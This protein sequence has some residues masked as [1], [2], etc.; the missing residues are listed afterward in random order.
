[1]GP[2]PYLALCFF[3]AGFCSNSSRSISSASFFTVAGVILTVTWEQVF[4]VPGI[5]RPPPAAG[6]KTEAVALL[7]QI[8][9]QVPDGISR[10]ADGV[11]KAAGQ[12]FPRADGK[13]PAADEPVNRNS[14][15]EGILYFNA[16]KAAA[17]RTSP[18]NVT[19]MT[20]SGGTA[21][22]PFFGPVETTVGPVP[23]CGPSLTRRTSSDPEILPP[24]KYPAITYR[25]S[26]VCWTDWP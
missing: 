8:A 4:A 10:D 9:V 23:P 18:L 20:L 22:A 25:P 1:M 2:V 26:A 13:E 21:V 5:L 24:V 16:V 6:G 12:P 19:V 15:V 17:A 7:Q 14:V 3:P 11:P